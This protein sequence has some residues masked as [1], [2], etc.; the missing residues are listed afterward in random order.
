M[1]MWCKPSDYTDW[2]GMDDGASIYACALEILDAQLK[3]HIPV[4]D[5]TCARGW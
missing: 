4:A 1:S 5:P 3:T 2:R